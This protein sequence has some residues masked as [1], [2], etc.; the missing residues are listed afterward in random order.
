MAPTGRATS[1]T[2]SLLRRDVQDTVQQD[3]EVRTLWYNNVV[4][5]T[6]HRHTGLEVW[7]QQ[8][9]TVKLAR[10]HE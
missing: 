10:I 7:S 3:T 9:A 4:T 1:W 8:L 2:R 6:D 5:Y